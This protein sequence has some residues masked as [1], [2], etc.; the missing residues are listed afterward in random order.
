[1]RR[2]RAGSATFTLVTREQVRLPFSLLGF[3]AAFRALETE[4]VSP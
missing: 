1:L 2:E 3:S 4:A